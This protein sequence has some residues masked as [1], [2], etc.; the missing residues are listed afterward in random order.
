MTLSLTGRT[1]CITV[2]I[3]TQDTQFAFVQ[4]T[5]Y[6]WWSTNAD[7]SSWEPSWKP[8]RKPPWEPPWEPPSPWPHASNGQP[9]TTSSSY[10]FSTHRAP[11]RRAFPTRAYAWRPCATWDET[12]W[13]STP[14]AWTS[15]TSTWYSSRNATKAWN[16]EQLSRPV[17]HRTTSTGSRRRTTTWP[18]T[19][20]GTR[21]SRISPRR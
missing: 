6:G 15:T 9:A 21:T 20:R 14:N 10:V 13:I 16:D 17:T 11:T 18:T 3:C 4:P 8:T 7:A 2:Q 19:K 12:S 1:T 5:N